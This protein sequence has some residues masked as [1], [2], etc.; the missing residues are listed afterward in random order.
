MVTGAPSGKEKYPFL[1]WR[2]NLVLGISIPAFVATKGFWVEAM[3][4]LSLKSNGN[5]ED[6]FLFASTGVK[7]FGLGGS[8]G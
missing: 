4:K 8:G 6:A 2:I 7:G 1:A 5:G 3:M